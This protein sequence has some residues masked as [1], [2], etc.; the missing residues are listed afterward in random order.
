[1]RWFRGNI[2]FGFWL[3]LFALMLNLTLSLGHGHFDG[4]VGNPESTQQ[5]AGL[6]GN[7]SADLAG[8]PGA[9]A[10]HSK[11]NY[12]CAI[13]VNFHIAGSV[14]PAEAPSLPL[15]VVASNVP[16][17]WYIELE[18]AASHCVPFDARGPPSS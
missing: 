9:P 2:R 8:V 6:T 18:L 5:P 14:L 15:G 16:P 11:L 13:C 4:V 10:R 12:H 17:G 1:M 7:Q 3:A